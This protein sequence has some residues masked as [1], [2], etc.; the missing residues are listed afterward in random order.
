MS[1]SKEVLTKCAAAIRNADA[2]LTCTGAG[3]GV[4][5]GLGT[6]RGR[7]AG[8]WPP[9]KAFSLDF[10]EMSDPRWFEDD[11]RLAWSFW[12]F[13]HQAYV[14]GTPHKGYEILANWGKRM[15]YGLF[16]ATSNIDGH[17]ARTDGVGEE[18]VYECHG[19][20]THMQCVKDSGR[21][22][23]TDHDE[24]SQMKVPV[25]DLA[26]GEKVEVQC[27]RSLRKCGSKEE[28]WVDAI[29]ADDGW[30]ILST[31]GKPMTVTAV[32]R[33]GGS[34]LTRV[35][36]ES[37]LPMCKETN[38]PARPNVLMF[39][40][41]GVNCDRIDAQNQQFSKWKA[42][43]PPD[44]KLLIV[45]IGAGTAIPTIRG[46]AESHLSSFPQSTLIRINL[47]ED[48]VPS[49]RAIAIGGLGALDALSRIDAAAQSE[50]P[51]E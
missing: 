28:E 31:A 30:S 16:S 44:C 51:R 11:A 40:D 49:E 46:I 17:W 15:R 12:H 34:D 29:V 5:S 48:S 25:W 41:F 35:H 14:N 10:S 21:I 32:R 1:L 24:I 39:G 9:L 23:S 33:P 27:G 42:S 2:L 3:M 4:D 7:N 20:V 6:F 36:P 38:Q 18:R 26:A 8:V 47:D 45:E 19:S 43:L 50:E 37:T 22:W 13:R